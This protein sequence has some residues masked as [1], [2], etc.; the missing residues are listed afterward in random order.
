MPNPEHPENN[1][2]VAPATQ[3]HHSRGAKA[4]AR[5]ADARNGQPPPHTVDRRNRG[6]GQESRRGTDRVV[7]PY[8]RPAQEPREVRASC[9]Q[10]RG[11]GARA[12]RHTSG[13]RRAPEG[14][15]DLARRTHRPLGMAYQQA[16]ARDRGTGQPAARAANGARKWGSSKGCPGGNTGTHSAKI[17]SRGGGER[18]PALVMLE[19]PKGILHFYLSIGLSKKG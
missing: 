7:R 1:T 14:Q 5:Q 17:K 16:R 13:T 2:R 12:R 8:Q 4:R 10:G 19:M 9:R 3:A 11:A 18:E 15:Q 6:P